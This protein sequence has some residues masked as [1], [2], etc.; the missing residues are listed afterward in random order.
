MER[1]YFDGGAEKWHYDDFIIDMDCPLCEWFRLNKESLSVYLQGLNI[2]ELSNL[3]ITKSLLFFKDFSLS[4]SQ[5]KI[6]KK[7]LKNI[8]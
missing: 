1:R 2:W 4:S 5:E 6:A 3:S 7:V 8:K